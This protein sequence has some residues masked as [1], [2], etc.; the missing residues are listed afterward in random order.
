MQVG[1]AQIVRSEWYD[2]SPLPITESYYALLTGHGVTQRILYTVPANR[3]LRLGSV[4]MNMSRVIINTGADAAYIDFNIYDDTPTLLSESRLLGL[5][6]VFLAKTDMSLSPDIILPAGYEVR[7][8]T[9]DK[10]IGG[11]IEY[12]ASFSG[13]EYDA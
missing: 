4:F 1:Q 7:I 12:A 13:T 10:G 5:D 6:N 3:V 2:R 9:S 11:S 8:Y